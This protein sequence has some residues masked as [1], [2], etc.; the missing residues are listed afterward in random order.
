MRY[1]RKQSRLGA[2]IKPQASLAP[3]AAIGLDFNP[4]AGRRLR[5]AI[6]SGCGLS[7][8]SANYLLRPRVKAQ[9]WAAAPD[10][11]QQRRSK[12]QTSPVDRRFAP[13]SGFDSTAERGRVGHHLFPLVYARRETRSTESP[14]GAVRVNTN[15]LWSSDSEPWVATNYFAASSLI[16]EGDNRANSME[17]DAQ[18]FA[19]GNNL[20][21]GYSLEHEHHQSDKLCITASDGGR[22][23]T[24]NENIAGRNGCFRSGEL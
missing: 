3:A 18:Q 14:T 17:L 11:R 16:G 13:K 12:E 15:L 19:L 1:C 21:G 24:A 9:P 2:R 6:L 22:H 20:L 4:V 23:V 10:V 7:I 5:L 8:L